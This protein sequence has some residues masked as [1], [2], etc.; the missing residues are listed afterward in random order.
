MGVAH[1]NV[2]FSISKN[3]DGFA[4]IFPMNATNNI[5]WHLMLVTLNTIIKK[6]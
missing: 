2:V 5:I 4:K 3:I 1:G 6:T